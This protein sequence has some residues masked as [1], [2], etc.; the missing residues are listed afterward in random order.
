VK[1]AKNDAGNRAARLFLILSWAL[2]CAGIVAAPL[3]TSS[4][5]PLAGGAT[6]L[7]FSQVCHQI[8]ER[9]FFLHGQPLAVCHR[10]SGIY[11]GLFLGSLISAGTFSPLLRIARRRMWVLAGAVPL[12]MDALGPVVGFWTNSALS[13]AATGALFGIMVSSL[14][15]SAATELFGSSRPWRVGPFRV[16]GGSR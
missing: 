7:L 16:H 12:W 4:S 5:R 15:H 9:S 1:R 14:L 6:Y 13:R 2:I 3:L 10:C 8:P 11:F